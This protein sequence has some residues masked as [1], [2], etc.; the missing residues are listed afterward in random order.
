MTGA[1]ELSARH[2]IH[3]V[4]PVWYGGHDGEEETLERCYRRCL[5]LV[6]LHGHRTVAFPS[7]GTGAGMASRSS[8]LRDCAA[9]D[10]DFSGKECCG[11]KDFSDL[12]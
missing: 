5:H 7:I 6:E 12:P 8:V 2:I 1:Y 10:H 4:G 9:G 11:G 3:A